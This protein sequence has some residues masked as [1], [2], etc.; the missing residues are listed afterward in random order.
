MAYRL[1]PEMHNRL[2]ATSVISSEPVLLFD[3]PFTVIHGERLA[4]ALR[5]AIRDETVKTIDKLRLI[6]NVDMVSDG[7]DLLED[8]TRRRSLMALYD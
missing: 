7:T 1:V 4:K 3:R 8:V 6:S 2:G 5:Q